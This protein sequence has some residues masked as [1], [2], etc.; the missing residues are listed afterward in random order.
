MGQHQERLRCRRR[1]GFVQPCEVVGIMHAEK[2]GA[3]T[4]TRLHQPQQHALARLVPE[5]R[6]PQRQQRHPGGNLIELLQHPLHRIATPH[7]LLH[8]RVKDTLP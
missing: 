3:R 2:E 6:L 4:P 1:K 7:G 5:H 8:L